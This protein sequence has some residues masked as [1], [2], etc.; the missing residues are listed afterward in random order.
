MYEQ[1]NNYTHIM[2]KTCVCIYIY[3]AFMYKMYLCMYAC[4]YT[5]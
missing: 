2:L 4:K 1:Y 5:M 3:I